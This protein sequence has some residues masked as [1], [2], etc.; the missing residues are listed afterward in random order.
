[1]VVFKILLIV[2]I[3]LPVVALSVYLYFQT[4]SYI[5]AR[6]LEDKGRDAGSAGRERR[7]R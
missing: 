6:N 4:I 1:M 7:R 5:R 2:L 3:A